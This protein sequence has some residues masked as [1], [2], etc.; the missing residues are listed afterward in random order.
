MRF[1]RLAATGLI[2][3]VICCGSLAAHAGSASSARRD[4]MFAKDSAESE[5]W[6][7]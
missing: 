4:L 5:R 3:G 2:A 1:S 6:L 7:R